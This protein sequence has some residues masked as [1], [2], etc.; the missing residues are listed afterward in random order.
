MPNIVAAIKFVGTVILGAVE[1]VG[2]IATG[3]KFGA[4]GSI[5][6]GVAVLASPAA[7]VAYP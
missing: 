3:A 1:T 2:V 4:V 5:I 7:F 6:A